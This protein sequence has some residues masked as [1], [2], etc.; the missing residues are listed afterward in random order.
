M[1]KNDYKS[2][3]LLTQ[4]FRFCGN[5]FRADTY[6]GCDFG[7]KYCFANYRRGTDKLLETKRCADL[8]IFEKALKYSS[9]NK[10]TDELVKNNVPIHLGGQADPF[11]KCEW[12]YGV[13]YSFFEIMK[14]YPVIISTKTNQLP[15]RYFNIIDKKTKCFQISIFSDDEREIR[16]YEENTPTAEERIEFVKELKKRGY[17]VSVRIQPIIN[18]ENALSLI[19]KVEKYTDFITV[20]HL[21]IQK[22]GNRQNRFEFFKLLGNEIAN[23]KLRRNYYKLPYRFL[24]NDIDRIKQIYTGKLGVGDNELL[25]ETTGCNCC[26][27]DEMPEIFNNW[28]KYNYLNIEKTGSKEHWYPKEKI[29]TGNI[30]TNTFNKYKQSNDFKLYVD[31]YC[32]EVYKLGERCLF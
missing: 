20:E 21:K 14:E 31:N 17:W 9:G 8:T 29:R 26:G 28:L 6:M 30:D 3:L 32:K 10:L 27:L 1:I 19:S 18:I 15:E 22:T 7:C 25:T 11:Q 5:P 16:K 24:K 12:E 2:C 4:Q 23:Y 13:T